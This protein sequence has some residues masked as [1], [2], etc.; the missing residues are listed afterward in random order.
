MPCYTPEDYTLA[1]PAKH[2]FPMQRYAKVAAHL[3]AAS[4]ALLASRASQAAPPPLTRTARSPDGVAL[5]V[6][7]PSI[8]IRSGYER[9]ATEEEVCLAHDPEFVRRFLA[10]T[11]L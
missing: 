3:G 8:E 7:P 1:L 11:P 10:G 6:A 9:L 2:T 5:Q 4:V